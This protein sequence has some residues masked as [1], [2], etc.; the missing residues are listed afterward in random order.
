[1]RV[2]HIVDNPGSSKE[3]L[4]YLTASAYGQDILHISKTV[5]M[6]PR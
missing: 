5:A 4:S 2:V 1:M 6:H 3:I